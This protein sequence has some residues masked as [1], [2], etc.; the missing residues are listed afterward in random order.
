M[1]YFDLNPSCSGHVVELLS[2][3]QTVG[4]NGRNRT[5]VV[6]VL[7]S[8]QQRSAYEGEVET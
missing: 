8:G 6:G 2:S 3:R 5:S 4:R 7:T 1:L